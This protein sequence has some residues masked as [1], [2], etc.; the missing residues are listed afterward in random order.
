MGF[1]TIALGIILVGGLFVACAGIN[2]YRYAVIIMSAASGYAIGRIICDSFLNGKVGEGVMRETNT[3]AVDSFV[4]AVCILGLA[5]LG[6]GIYQIMGTLVA[7]VGGAFLLSKISMAL[8]GSDMVS[9]MIGAFAGLILGALISM[10]AIKYE[11]FALIIFTAL[12]GGRVAGYAAAGLLKANEIGALIAK[13]CIGLFSARF[14]GDA[15]RLS[16]A[17]ELFVVIAVIGVVVQAILR[18]D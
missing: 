2:F 6:Y 7:A 1:D 14:P 9:M 16:I 12:A 5:A 4:M 11:G 8:M 17:L 18:D 13:P 3:T 15:V 10:L